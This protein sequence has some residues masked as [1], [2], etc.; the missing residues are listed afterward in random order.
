MARKQDWGTRINKWIE[1]GLLEMIHFQLIQSGFDGPDDSF[2]KFVRENRI[3]FDR[4]TMEAIG[5]NS[6]YIS[7]LLN[8]VKESGLSIDP[9]LE[10]KAEFYTFN[11]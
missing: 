3:M 4:N 8:L 1:G 11:G 7:A 9:A 5:W 10:K 2:K 6:G